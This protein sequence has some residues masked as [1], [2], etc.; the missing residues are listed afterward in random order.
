M[1]KYFLLH[2]LVQYFSDKPPWYESLANLRKL[3][4][5]ISE[6][7]IS[8]VVENSSICSIFPISGHAPNDFW[9]THPFRFLVFSKQSL[10]CNHVPKTLKFFSQII[11]NHWLW[12]S[13]PE[14]GPSRKFVNEG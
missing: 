1:R 2:L 5:I 13:F 10:T 6:A 9:K 7:S 14:I 3:V 8:K 4:K 11:L 12:M